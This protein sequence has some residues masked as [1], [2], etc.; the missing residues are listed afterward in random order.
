VSEHELPEIAHHDLMPDLRSDAG[1]P[2]MNRES[3][4]TPEQW[5]FLVKF[6][7][8]YVNGRKFLCFAARAMV[9]VGIIAGAFAAIGTAYNILLHGGH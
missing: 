1:A 9:A 8:N 4:M 3:T 6:S 5:A 7:A 2:W